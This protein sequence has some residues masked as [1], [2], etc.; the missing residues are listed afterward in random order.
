MAKRLSLLFSMPENFGRE[1]TCSG[2]PPPLVTGYSQ[3]ISNNAGDI[4][5]LSTVSHWIWLR[6]CSHQRRVSLSDV[7]FSTL[8]A[9][10]R[11]S[12]RLDS[13]PIRSQLS[14]FWAGF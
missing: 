12:T 5:S 6:L 11:D 13:T 9:T 7:I 8:D 1:H 14:T 10:Q 2:R 3:R 4:W